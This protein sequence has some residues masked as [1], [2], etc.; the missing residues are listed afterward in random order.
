MTFFEQELRKIVEP[1]YPDA[2]F[3]GRACY[4]RLSDVNRAKLEFVTCGTADRYEA[5]QMTILNRGSG[6]VDTLQLRFFDIWGRGQAR[7]C[8]VEV[9]GPYIWNDHGEIEWYAYHPSR[10]EYEDLA[11]KVADY[12][13]VFQEQTQTADQH[14]QQTM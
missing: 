11:G 5:L 8:L 13:E 14:W 1:A 3:V 7:N 4:V 9:I 2:T 10:N 12:L 6:P